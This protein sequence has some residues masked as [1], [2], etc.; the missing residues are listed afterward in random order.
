MRQATSL[1]TTTDNPIRESIWNW[2]ELLTMEEPIT[3]SDCSPNPAR[4]ITAV[5]QLMAG[6]AASREVKEQ[7][8]KLTL[9]ILA[10]LILFPV[11][12]KQLQNNDIVVS[13]IQCSSYNNNSSSFALTVIQR[14]VNDILHRCSLLRPLGVCGSCRL[15]LAE[16]WSLGD[17]T[18]DLE[19]RL[20]RVEVVVCG[21]EKFL[22][23]KDGV[24]PGKE[25]ERLFWHGEP[26]S[27]C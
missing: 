5:R 9:H 2:M 23:G 26:Y 27:A 7:R 6:D 24:G 21:C 8:L 4:M 11:S 22:T 19:H 15:F 3:E 20:V 14:I 18:K 16:A 13:T 12:L 17:E 1:P 10:L 25:A